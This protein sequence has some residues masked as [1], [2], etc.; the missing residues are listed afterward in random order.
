MNP[1]TKSFS[2]ISI[3]IQI[4][5]ALLVYNF[6]QN[7]HFHRTVDGFRIFHAHPYQ[8]KNEKE[9]IK[10]HSH[11]QFEFLIFQ[12]VSSLFEQG[13]WIIWIPGCVWQNL[14][15]IRTVHFA[16]NPVIARPIGRAPPQTKMTSM[17]RILFFKIGGDAHVIDFRYFS[18][19][20]RLIPW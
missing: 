6:I 8:P 18:V 17:F 20:N 10:T 4:S 3:A 9:P 5:M 1:R 12:F 14:K 15:R 13:F 11:S 7:G 2:L 19:R 16:H